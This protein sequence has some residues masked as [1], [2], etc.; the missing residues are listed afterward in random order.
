MRTTKKMPVALVAL[1]AVG[2]IAAGC[3]DEDGGDDGESTATAA[4][5]AAGV[6]TGG[7]DAGGSADAESVYEDC[8]A[9]AQYATEEAAQEAC[10]QIQ[11]D[12]E[13]CIASG[14]TNLGTPA[15]P[16]ECRS[17]ALPVP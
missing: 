10:A 1:L 11:Q 8:V 2:L 12:Y 13:D 5:S 6:E 7:A 15:T 3:G 17:A 9:S 14:Q 4:E 16:E